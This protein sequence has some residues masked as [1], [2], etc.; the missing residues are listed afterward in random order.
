M[1]TFLTAT[2]N[3][4]L[5]ISVSVIIAR[6]LGPEGKGIYTVATLFSYLIVTF[7]S[8]GLPSSA[9]F[10]VAKQS[11]VRQ[12]ILGSTVLTGLLTGALG[13]ITGLILVILM[14]Q[15]IFPGISQKYLVL[16][17]LI[18]PGNMLLIHLQYIL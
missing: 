1:I 7:G 9:T 6:V 2:L 17:L 4:V 14:G 3:L 12:E 10:Y 18:I 13:M 5:G 16:A 11:Y 8:L 15:H